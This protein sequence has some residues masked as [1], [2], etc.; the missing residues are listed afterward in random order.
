MESYLWNGP[1]MGDGGRGA[2]GAGVGSKTGRW[3][4]KVVG[5]G[6]ELVQQFEV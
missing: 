1:G 4:C 3:A 6:L 5:A 2:V